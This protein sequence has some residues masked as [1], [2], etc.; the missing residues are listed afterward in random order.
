MRNKAIM[1]SLLVLVSLIA[2]ASPAHSQEVTAD[3]PV[4]AQQYR[5]GRLAPG[6]TSEEKVFPLDS[7][8]KVRVEIVANVGGLNTSIVTPGSQT[9]NPIN[10]ASIGGAYHTFEATDPTEGLV[11]VPFHTAGFH[12]IYDLPSQGAGNYTVRVESPSNPTGEIAYI[13][14]VE[15]NSAIRTALFATQSSVVQGQPAV[16]SAAVFNGANAISGAT[17]TVTARRGTDTP[18]TFT[19]LDNGGVADDTAGDGLYSGEFTPAAT[20]SYAILAEITGTTNGVSY[21]RH[22]LAQI[23]VIPPTSVFTGTV[24][25]HGI[26]D[27]SDGLFDRLA[28]DVQTNTTVAGDYSIV[29]QLKTAS[30]K[31]IR[32]GI[33]ATLPTG[34]S[35]VSVHFE[36]EAI[37]ETGENGPYAIEL[38]EMFHVTETETTV[39]DRLANAGQTSAYT[40]LQFQRP[41]LVV[42]NVNTVAGI[43]NNANGKYDLLRVTSQVLALKAGV[44]EWSGTLVDAS[45][46]EIAFASGERVFVAGN[47][48]MTFDFDGNL[49][50]QHGATGSYSVR[51][52]A[53]FGADESLIVDHLLDTQPFSFKEFENAENLRL[54]TVATQETAG[55]GNGFVEPGENGSLSVQLRNIGGTSISGINATLSVLSPGVLIGSGQSAYPTIAASG[56]GTNTTPFTFTLSSTIPCGEVLRLRLTINHTGDGGIPSVVNFSIQPGRPSTGPAT[57]SYTGSPVAIPDENLAG[58]NIPITV[59]G[60]AGKLKDLNFRFG[61]SSCSATPGATTVGLDHTFVGDLSITLRSPSGTVVRLLH[62]PGA[63][64]EPSSGNNFCNTVFDDEGGGSSIQ[65]IADAANPYSGT[66]IPLDPLSVLQGE[67]PNGTW[68]L[69]VAD[70]VAEDIG[71]VRDFSLIIS[72]VTCD[73][74]AQQPILSDNFNDN[75][76]D[77][78]KWVSNDLFSGFTDNWLPLNETGQRLEIGPLSQAGSG[79]HY[80]GIRSLH[81]YAFTG[82]YTHVELAQAPALNST[83]DAMFTVGYSSDNY[84]RIYENNGSLFGLKRV[85]GV[86]TTLFTISYN[87]TN[88]RFWRIRHDAGTNKVVFETAPSAGSAPGAWTERY[89]ETWSSAVQ[90]SQMQFE[91]K[92]GTFQPEFN[93]PGKVIFDNFEYGFSAPVPPGPPTIASA[94]PG[95][96]STGGGT[97]VTIQGT[98]FMTGATVT[99]GGT[100]ATSVVVSSAGT[101][102]AVAPAHAEGA[103][104]VVVTNPDA[105]SVTLTNG[106]TYTTLP[107][108]VLLEENFS[109]NCFDT[110]KWTAQ[111]LYSGFTDLSVPISQTG[112]R[113]EIGPLLQGAA[114]SGSHYRGIRTINRYDFGGAY[115]YVELAQAPS[116]ATTGD[117]MFTVGYDV[118]NYYRIFV[119]AGTLK[120][121][122][123]IGGVIT[124]VFTLSYDSTNHRFWRIRHDAGTNSLVL[125]TAPSAGSGPGTWT[126]RYSETW[127]SA[128]QLSQI[129]FELKGG[130]WQTEPNAPGKVIF[131]NFLISR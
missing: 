64:H 66:F 103:V 63:N 81:T 59:S 126:T 14:Q 33:L 98:G 123:K 7:S 18:V 91:M 15:T 130:T 13:T 36:A 100:S 1:L 95:S 42:T 43:D 80:R 26:D 30:G 122:K 62:Q 27:N 37:V 65:N 88:H 16:F 12:Y 108:N 75:S 76:L 127:N 44:Y 24:G 86:K 110:S 39:A 83:A 89:N 11:V 101:I 117:A 85:S 99:F 4:Q 25:D 120:G 29:A 20:G 45:G 56:T 21:T 90:L 93:A 60:V 87:S 119:E 102:T 68:T 77:A 107:P 48:L 19:L 54:G 104:N 128:V 96:G 40:L 115:S 84:Y 41:P 105:Q 10:V 82:G 129:Q 124:T 28:L 118:N 57:F 71:S 111:D 55:N 51:S 78:T 114:A 9:I 92:G 125:E 113:L 116:S 34:T 35:T 17:V 49:I 94:C 69:N 50:G 97:P 32:R 53:L 72:D 61:G 6:I 3:I 70:T 131:D 52:V 112:Q 47:N 73:S 74:T 22:S 5:L 23:T 109:S 121:V 8:S 106:F 2:L 31:R 46:Q 58:V 38:L 79:S 67:D